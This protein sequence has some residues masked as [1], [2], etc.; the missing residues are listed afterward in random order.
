MVT[1]SGM[2]PGC[3]GATLSVTGKSATGALVRKKINV[4]VVFP[5]EERLPIS[6]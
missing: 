3:I 6:R 2:N 1:D 4:K 5:I